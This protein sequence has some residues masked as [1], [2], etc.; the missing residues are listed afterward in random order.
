M[1]RGGSIGGA[2]MKK[3]FFLLIIVARLVAYDL[4]S[5][6]H[7]SDRQKTIQAVIMKKGAEFDLGL[8]LAAIAWKSL[9]W[10]CTS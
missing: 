6:A 7:P 1:D 4:E 3:V 5:V 9:L 10:G 2:K 8:T